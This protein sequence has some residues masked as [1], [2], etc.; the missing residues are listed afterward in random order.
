M[1]LAST[2]ENG[3][4]QT[5]PNR[6]FGIESFKDKARAEVIISA[7]SAKILELC[8]N[9]IGEITA[10]ELG[11]TGDIRLALGQ[12]IPCS[13]SGI[14]IA[15]GV[16]LIDPTLNSETGNVGFISLSFRSE[17]LRSIA[18]ASTIADGEAVTVLSV[19]IEP[20]YQSTKTLEN[21]IRA[22]TQITEERKIP[23]AFLR[24]RSDLQDEEMGHLVKKLGYDVVGSGRKN[25]LNLVKGLPLQA[26]SAA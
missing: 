15:P 13:Q 7:I 8:P 20:Q 19:G 11:N 18:A 6:T 4:T 9:T 21:I 10:L 22:V 17:S 24:I 12:R 25:S 23:V 1:T 5:Q 16:K 26:Q 14:N 3:I 2:S